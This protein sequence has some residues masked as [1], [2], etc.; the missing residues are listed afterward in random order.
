M[1]DASRAPLAVIGLSGS[2]LRYAEIERDAAGDRSAGRIPGRLLRLGTCDFEVDIEKGVLADGAPYAIQGIGEALREVFKDTTAQALVVVAHPPHTTSFFTPV[3][4][5]MDAAARDEQLRQEAALLADVGSEE[6]VRVRAVPLRL[7][8]IGGTP[9]RWHHV[10]HV[11][12]PIHARLSLLARALGVDRYD[13]SDSPRAAAAIVRA[14]A[15]IQGGASDAIELAVGAY[16]GHTEV[17]VSRG[18]SWL[19]GHHGPGASPEDTAYF[20]L[21][22]LER[23]G[24]APANVD[25]LHVYGDE[26]P[27]GARLSVLSS[28][29][30]LEASPLDPLSLYGRRPEGISADHLAGFAPVLG[31]TLA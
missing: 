9:H 22:A 21:A 2:A 12:E 4:E 18:R 31:A 20:A 7:D 11:S 1:P 6:P 3:P 17:S 5:G 30:D 27:Q 15:A 16:S 28:L 25:R 24:I 26:G 19:F 13:L 8:A 23:I 29:L 10:T 14:T